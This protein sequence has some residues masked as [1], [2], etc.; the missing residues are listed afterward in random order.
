MPAWPAALP[1][2]NADGF[3]EAWQDGVVRTQMDAGPAFQRRRYTATPRYVTTTL[4]LTSAQIETL[5]TFFR[6]TLLGGGAWFDWEDPR[7][8]AAAQLRFRGPPAIS[9][10][11]G[12]LYPVSLSLEIAA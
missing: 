9:S 2:F 1:E 4:Y 5:R 10:P 3:S 8:G 7:T 11:D 12:D 6:D